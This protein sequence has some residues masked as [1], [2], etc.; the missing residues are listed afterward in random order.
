MSNVAD[1]QSHQVPI[2]PKDVV[3][4]WKRVRSLP[5]GQASSTWPNKW[6]REDAD[7]VLRDSVNG[8]LM[9]CGWRLEGDELVPL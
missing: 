9:A 7:G 3:N 5:F 8:H 1:P 4:I 2:R 6:I